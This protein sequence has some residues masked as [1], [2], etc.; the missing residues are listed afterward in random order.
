MP[1]RAIVIAGISAFI[2]LCGTCIGIH[3]KPI[4]G[5]LRA[6]APAAQV[7]TPPAEPSPALAVQ[8]A[9]D[10]ILAEPGACFEPGTGGLTMIGRAR[11]DAIYPILLRYPAL[12]VEVRGFPDGPAGR[13]AELATQRAEAARAYLIFHGILENRIS[14]AAQDVRQG[15]QIPASRF[16]L[17]IY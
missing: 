7:P 14:S 5:K 6:A 2:I 17:R 16:S 11:L 4:M 3:L 8:E 10:R 12:R 15:E 1:T 13:A 9:V